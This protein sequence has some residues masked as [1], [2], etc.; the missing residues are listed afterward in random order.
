MKRV[1]YILLL[2]FLFNFFAPIHTV[3]AEVVF[4]FNSGEYHVVYIKDN[5]SSTTCDNISTINY[6]ESNIEH[7][8][9]FD[10]YKE[11]YTYM[12]TLSSTSSKIVSIIGKRKDTNGNYVNKILN[13]EYAYV[14][15]NTT[16]TTMTVS[17]VYTN[18]LDNKAYTYI[19]GHGAFGGVDAAF[20][21]Y[22]N[23]SA[24]ANIKI[25]GVTGWISSLLT[26]KSKTYNGY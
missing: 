24:R 22:D 14:D 23:E 20:I 3:F 17:N 7:V 21:E 2:S 19:N 25:S 18:K 26:L 11:A 16:G 15:L 10:T 9:S 6:D 5:E 1:A 4:E 13:S 12:K 8:K